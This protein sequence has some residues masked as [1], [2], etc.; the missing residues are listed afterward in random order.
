M[1]DR[2]E[3]IGALTAGRPLALAPD[4]AVTEVTWTRSPAPGD[5]H[6]DGEQETPLDAHRAAHDDG[7]PSEAVVRYGAGSDPASIADRLVGL[8]ELSAR[9]GLLRAVCPVPGTGDSSRPGSWGVEDLSMI[10]IA[11]R[12]MPEVPWIRP[13]WRLLGPAACQV[14]VGFGANDWSIP[15]DDATDP[16]HLAAAIGCRA[17]ER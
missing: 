10:A 9:T 12:V 14:A 11:R 4:E 16:G 17:V 15:E 13:S 3:I 5:W 2:A 6:L 7:R 8:A 1:R